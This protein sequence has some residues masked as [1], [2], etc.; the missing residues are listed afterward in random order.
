ML[1]TGGTFNFGHYSN[2]DADRFMDEA[3]LYPD[4]AKRRELYTQLWQ[5]ERRDMPLLYLYTAR[6]VVGMKKGLMGFQQVPDGLIRLRGVT[7]SR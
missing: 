2:P 5:Q 6:N 7:L 3:R 1:H 4:V